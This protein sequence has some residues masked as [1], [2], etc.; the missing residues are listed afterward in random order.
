MTDAYIIPNG[1]SIFFKGAMNDGV[2]L[3]IDFIAH[4]NK[5]DISSNYCIEPN[6]AVVAHTH[7]PN[8]CSIG[9]YKYIITKNGCKTS[10]GKNERHFFS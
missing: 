9:C 8:N 7:L 10:N 4:F 6:T 5:V 2:V 1:G 3:Y